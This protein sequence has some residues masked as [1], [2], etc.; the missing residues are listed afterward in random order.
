MQ[1]KG[2]F[3]VLVVQLLIHLTVFVEVM[4]EA[5]SFHCTPGT[6]CICVWETYHTHFI[7]ITAMVKAIDAN[8]V[9]KP[10]AFSVVSYEIHPLGIPLASHKQESPDW[11]TGSHSVFSVLFVQI[12]A[13]CVTRHNRSANLLLKDMRSYPLRFWWCIKFP[14]LHLVM[15][16]K[17]HS[18]YSR[19]CYC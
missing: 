10:Q 11:T 18:L 16:F 1:Y 2:T 17:F 5:R 15:F 8:D 4:V 6:V 19:C 14:V 12:N 9:P 7:I 3:G 13:P